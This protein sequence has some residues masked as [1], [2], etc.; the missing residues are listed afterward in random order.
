MAGPAVSAAT[1]GSKHLYVVDRGLDDDL[2]IPRIAPTI[3]YDNW[4]RS[5]GYPDFDHDKHLHSR[6]RSGSGN[7]FRCQ[8]PSA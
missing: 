7:G 6:A 3:Q 4:S 1:L 8:H 2:L 5:I